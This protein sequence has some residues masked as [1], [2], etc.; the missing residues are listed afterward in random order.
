MVYTSGLCM[1]LC[2]CMCMSPPISPTQ[3]PLAHTHAH[4]HNTTQHSSSSSS[5]HHFHHHRRL[6][7]PLEPAVLHIIPHRTTLADVRAQLLALLR[8]RLQLTWELSKLAERAGQKRLLGEDEEE[9]EEEEGGGDLEG[10]LRAL[11]AGWELV[12]ASPSGGRRGWGRE[13]E[14]VLVRV[15]VVVGVCLFL[16]NIYCGWMC[17]FFFS[18]FD[19]QLALTNVP[20]HYL[21]H[22]GGEPQRPIPQRQGRRQQQPQPPPQQQQP[23]PPSPRR[24]RGRGRGA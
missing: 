12:L 9:D 24:R 13:Q 21:P 10:A 23:Q 7:L 18:H 3:L 20:I 17:V 1:F 11:A 2:L 5:S 4:T 8:P 14:V 16:K 19:S 22:T 6:P 15:V